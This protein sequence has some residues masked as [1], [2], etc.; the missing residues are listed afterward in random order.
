MFDHTSRYYTID[1]AVLATPSGGITYVRRRFPPPGASLPVMMETAAAPG[2]RIDLLTNRVYG[3]P[4][5]FWRICDANDAIDPLEMLCEA[6]A[7]PVRRL[8]VP[9]PQA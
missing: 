3:D 4:L 9:L 5:L 1:T 7:D 2:E 6:A 8:R